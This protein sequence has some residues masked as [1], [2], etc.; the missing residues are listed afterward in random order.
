MTI[1]ALV[2]LGG[3]ALIVLG[4]CPADPAVAPAGDAQADANS[5][6]IG[7]SG[8]AAEDLAEQQRRAAAWLMSDL[9]NDGLSN[10]IEEEYGLDP[11]DPNDGPDIDGDGV[12]N[13]ADSDI[14]GDG[15]SNDTDA[16]IDG[17]GL[18]NL[19]D[20]DRDGDAIP[21][22]I[23]LDMDADGIRN[24][25]DHD[26]DSDGDE[27]DE[28]EDEDDDDDDEDEDEDDPNDPG[29]DDGDDDDDDV[30]LKEFLRLAK[31]TALFEDDDDESDD[32]DPEAD[33]EGILV[34]TRASPPEVTR[35]AAHVE[36]LNQLSQNGDAN[37]QKQ[38]RRLLLGIDAGLLTPLD[39]ESEEA[40]KTAR[41]FAKRLGYNEVSTEE[42]LGYIQRLQVIS[43]PQRDDATEALTVLD[44]HVSNVKKTD[45][46]SPKDEL[47]DQLQ[48]IER[49]A[50]EFVDLGA[51]E[52]SDSILELTGLLRDIA[53]DDKVDGVLDL[54]ESVE[55]PNVHNLVDGFSWLATNLEGID[56]E[57]DLDRAIGI[58]KTVPGVEDGIDEE[59]LEEVEE[60]W[61][62]EPVPA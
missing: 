4:G 13:Y 47:E 1:R 51:T 58:L 62:A 49:L 32:D 24:L 12:L 53:L 38:L 14:D 55:N 20:R 18:F 52:L 15:I 40:R 10:G 50:G 26:D 2:W 42:M 19:I 39:P 41:Y 31:A 30:V 27:E 6:A 9:D 16:D 61:E 8:P 29:G 59:D 44:K 28:D 46:V 45:P 60:E 11:T 37:A 48:N 5:P 21:D 36:Q 3:A 33:A 22:R 35:F 34:D 54:G 25:W 57:E 43:R 17:D 56:T 7:A 23:D